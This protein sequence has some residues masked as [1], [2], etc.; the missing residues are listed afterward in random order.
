MCFGTAPASTS[1]DSLWSP[2]VI[3]IAEVREIV[4]AYPRLSALSTCASANKRMM[5]RRCACGG[6]RA[7]NA[8]PFVFPMIPMSSMLDRGTT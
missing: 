4:L 7:R 5:S 2:Q 8:R 3:M 1:A 6:P